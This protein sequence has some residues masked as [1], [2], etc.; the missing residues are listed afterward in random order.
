VYVKVECHCQSVSR[1]R[2]K[3]DFVAVDYR[4]AKKSLG[5]PG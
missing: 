3:I 2:E 1:R 5:R 4:R